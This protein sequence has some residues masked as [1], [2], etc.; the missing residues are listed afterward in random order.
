AQSARPDVSVGA[1]AQGHRRPPH[2]VPRRTAYVRDADASAGVPIAVISAWLGHASK[3][4]TMATYV[5]SQMHQRNR[6][7]GRAQHPVHH[8]VA[9][10]RQSHR[11]SGGHRDDR[12]ERASAHLRRT[13]TWDRGSE[14]A[15]W[16]NI[17]LQLQ[18]PVYICD[19]HSPWQRGTNESDTMRL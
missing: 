12:D 5:H 16:R 19:P 6:H 10:A 2:P 8:L 7:T 13:I 4:F 3:A 14:M 9:P 11:R 15:N 17:D 18:A 1:H